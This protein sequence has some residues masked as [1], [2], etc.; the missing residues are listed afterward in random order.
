MPASWPLWISGIPLPAT[1]STIAA[2]RASPNCSY[3]VTSQAFL[4]WLE[5]K[6]M[7]MESRW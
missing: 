5:T 7:R 1:E 2:S 6:S 3:S 4:S